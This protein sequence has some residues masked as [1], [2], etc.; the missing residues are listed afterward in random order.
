MNFPLLFII[1]ISFPFSLSFLC[2]GILS[3]PLTSY[4]LMLRGLWA[5]LLNMLR[6]LDVPSDS[7][8]Y[9]HISKDSH[10]QPL[11]LVYIASHVRYYSPVLC[12][13]NLPNPIHSGSLHSYPHLCYHLPS[14]L[15]TLP[16]VLLLCV[17]T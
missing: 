7:I 15:Y 17:V 3:E 13:S 1:Y 4:Y 12:W 14:P 16:L 2:F 10:A 11:R 5:P 6:F 8:T 9:C